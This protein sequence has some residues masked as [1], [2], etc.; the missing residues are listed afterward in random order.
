MENAPDSISMPFEITDLLLLPLENLTG[1]E[2]MRRDGEMA[3]ATAADG[4]PRL[5][6]YTWSPWC[7][8]LG[9]HQDSSGFDKAAISEKGYDI[10]QRPTGGRAVFHAEELTY[11][12]TAKTNGATENRIVYSWVHILLAEVFSSLDIIT[13]FEKANSDFKSHY[14]GNGRLSCFTSS[15]RYELTLD[16]KKFVG[17]AQRDYGG[18]LLQHGSILLGPAH[19]SMPD[20]ILAETED[21]K[22]RLREMLFQ[23][24]TDVESATGKEISPEQ[25]SKSILEKLEMEK[26]RLVR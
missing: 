22:S 26:Q 6:L 23:S 14:K 21:Y 7:I 16:G 3:L 20:L 10:V 4:L 2:N 17:S 12:I 1:E 15:A 13:D 25:L 24:S 9:K 19:F 18:Y 5:R 11:C 8:S